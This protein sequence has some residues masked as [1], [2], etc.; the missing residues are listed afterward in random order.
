MVQNCCRRKSEIHTLIHLLASELGLPLCCLLVA[1]YA[2]SGYDSVSTFSHI[3][4]IAIFET[5]KNK[6]DELTNMIDFG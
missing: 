2:I 6:I 1:M 4:K 3:E 5:F